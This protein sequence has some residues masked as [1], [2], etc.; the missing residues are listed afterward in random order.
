MLIMNKIYIHREIES[1]L[2]RSVKQFPAIAVTGPRQSGKSTLLREIFSKTHNYVTFDDPIN[3]EQAL[4]DPKLFLE[5]AGQKAIID[6]IQYAPQILSYIKIM[7]DN[8]RHEK[9][10]FIFTGSQ[11]FILIKNLGDSLAGRIALF[12][13]LPFDINEKRRVSGMGRVLDTSSKCFV[14][15]CLFGS[16]PEVAVSRDI[17]VNTWYSAYLQ[18]Y[19]ERDVR[20]TYN[21]GKLRDFQLFIQLLA[22]RCSQ[23]LNLTSF[24]NDLGIGVNTIKRWI[25]ILEA[26]R[27]IYLL[28]PYY[29]NFG[30][31]LTKSPKIYFLDC[32]LVC[33]LVGIKSRE[34][35]LKGPMAGQLFENFYIQETVKHFFNKG[36]RPRLYYIRS[37]NKLEIDLMI[38]H[39][40]M[41][42]SLIKIKFSKTPRTA[43]ASNINKF[44]KNFPKL[45]IRDSKILSLSDGTIQLVD[46]VSFQG[47]DD[48]LACL[49]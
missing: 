46:G 49:E 31:R 4:S 40:N 39:S 43:M 11:Q 21:I 9:G 16:F 48:Y 1:A 13:L 14:H 24:S 36:A 19:L 38:E 37:H 35:L 15:S 44:K 18:T 3:R 2:K 25:S 10:R 12:D 23:I 32:G 41:N 6:E 29:Q 45:K 27:I 28:P 22:A 33:Y 7:I 20:T 30:K 34:L 47:L 8:K 26:S 42:V 17:D 5:N